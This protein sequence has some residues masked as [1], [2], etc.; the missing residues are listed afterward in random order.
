METITE[1]LT[2]WVIDPIHSQIGFKV[3]HLMFTNVRGKFDDYKASISTIGNDFTTVR[4]EVRI[5][6]ASVNTNDFQ[7]DEHL[8]SA[9]FFDIESWKDITFTSTSYE[10]TK[11]N[12]SYGLFGDLTIKGITKLIRLEMESGG[13]LKDPW[14]K[15]KAIFNILG[16][17]NRKDWGLNWNAALEAGGVLVG[18]DVWINC[19]IQLTRES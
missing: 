19:E 1:T 7:R 16:R 8:R 9:D 14:G 6:P 12:E 10:R 3:K 17:I 4:I 2:K 11:K 18:E 13:I 15:E 5:N